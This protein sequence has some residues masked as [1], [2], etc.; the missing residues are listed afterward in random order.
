MASRIILLVG[1]AGSGKSTYARKQFPDAMVV[2]A[3]HH[4]EALA[5]RSRKSYVEVWDLKEQGIAHSLCQQH[6]MDAIAADHPIVIVDNTNVRSAD[7]QRYVK[8]GLEFGC[9]TEFH[10]FSP[11]IFGE[12][13]PSSEN[14]LTYV[15][16]C[17]DRQFHGVPLEIIAQQFSRLDLP[18]G[19]Y[20][21]G[22]PAQYL[23]P[24]PERSNLLTSENPGA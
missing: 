3:D 18:S 10:V 24:I 9:E 17:Y 5:K 20:L 22:K 21:A 16:L 19:I 23:R 13:P 1:C 15:R 4:F 8:M 14:I 12:P 2:S 11:R 6:F 7:R